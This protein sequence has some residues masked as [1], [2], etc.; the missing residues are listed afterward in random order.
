MKVTISKKQNR[1]EQDR[2][3]VE[4]RCLDSE[5]SWNE[6]ER[7]RRWLCEVIGTTAPKAKIHGAAPHPSPTDC[8]PQHHSL[9]P[10]AVGGGVRGSFIPQQFSKVGAYGERKGDNGMAM[11]SHNTRWQADLQHWRQQTQ[12][13]TDFHSIWYW[14]S[15]P[16]QL[17][18]LHKSCSSS[19]AADTC[20]SKLSEWCQLKGWDGNSTI[21]V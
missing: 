11:C 10:Q 20:T 12:Q 16:H 18:C 3:I 21:I 14:C 6:M 17:T 1:M 2:H 5:C 7:H 8:F 19:T 4:C 15:C 9:P 13:E